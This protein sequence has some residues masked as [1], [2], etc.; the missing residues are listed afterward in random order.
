VRRVAALLGAAYISA[1]AAHHSFPATYDM[2]ATVE[3]EGEIA[4]L[5]WRNP[6]VVINVRTHDGVHWRVEAD[7]MGALERVG[8]S[9]RRLSAGRPVRIAGYPARD[10]GAALYA[11][12]V[13]LDGRREFLVR[14]AV[15]PRW[16]G[17]VD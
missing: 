2:N 14:P 3:I 1:T 8:L 12:H 13:L 9:R 16:T 7:P 5:E 11:S 6:H 17:V 10:G 15:P 4:S